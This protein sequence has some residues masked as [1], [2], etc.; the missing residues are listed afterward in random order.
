MRLVRSL[1]HRNFRL[2]FAGQTLSLLGVWMQATANGWLIWRLTH[3]SKWLGA[4]GFASQIPVLI[5]GLFAGVIADRVFRHR[6]VIGVQVVAMMQA[7]V[8]A[9]L[10]ITDSITPVMVF[11]L[12]FCLGLVFAFDYPSRQS[13][14]MDM[15][16]R[17]DI[18]NAVAINS[19]TVHGA[20][21]VGPVAAGF[22]VA[23]WGE[24]ACFAINAVSYLFVIIALLMM[25]KEDFFAQEISRNSSWRESIKEAINVAWRSP[26]IRR[27]L[28]LMA[29]LSF[30][31]M[32]YVFIMPQVVNETFKGGAKE[33]GVAMSFAGFGALSGAVTLAL[34][35]QIDGLEKVITFSAVFAGLA[36]VLL[37]ASHV[38]PVSLLLLVVVGYS[39]FLVVAGT[40]TI[41]QTASPP[42]YRGRVMSLFTVIFFGFAPLGS[43]LTGEL[44]ARLGPHVS[45]ALGGG[46]TFIISL[47]MLS[48]WRRT[49]RTKLCH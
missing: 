2:F 13:F 33:L 18:G 20:R 10:T 12:T 3:S 29:V 21:V 48:L 1:S 28:M 30:A 25:R 15:V 40:N 27:P 23:A 49:D 37:A 9:I 11:I 46:A 45:V 6:L 8:L 31:S 5:F 17:E 47:T 14:L 16:G 36:L 39:T 4:M 24:G 38:A 26:E 7:S 34:R 44:A 41:V 32:P 35:K 19:S 43:L 22:I 42:Q